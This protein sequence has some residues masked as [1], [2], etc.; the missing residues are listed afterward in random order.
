MQVVVSCEHGG[1]DVPEPW[2]AFFAGHEALLESHRGWDPGALAIARL[3]AHVLR[4]P[5][6]AST[7]SR[8]LIDL[9]RSRGHPRRYSE[10]TRALPRTARAAI[11]ATHW[12]PWRAAV[13]EAVATGIGRGATVLH[14]SS[15]SF[16]PV[17]DGARRNFQVGLLYDPAR[18]GERA[19]CAAWARALRERGVSVRMNRPYAGRADGLVT[20]LR[21]LH[22]PDTYLGVELE[23]NQAGVGRALRHAVTRALCAALAVQAAGSPSTARRPAASSTSASASHSAG[24]SSS[25]Q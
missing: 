13:M 25:P 9:N 4:A 11:E 15:H 18:P 3:L 19:L 23:L 17:L 8:L 5:L 6:H 14:L 2:R 10:I 21:R 7:V 12:T 1:H 22:G 20:A 16:T 24:G